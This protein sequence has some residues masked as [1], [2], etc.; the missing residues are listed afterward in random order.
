MHTSI[1]AWLLSL[2]RDD[3]SEGAAIIAAVKERDEARRAGRALGAKWD[4]LVG[5][6]A[7][8]MLSVG[9]EQTRG[10]QQLDG[11]TVSSLKRAC[12]ALIGSR[13]EAPANLRREVG[14][15][16]EKELG[17]ADYGAVAS[18]ILAWLDSLPEGGKG[19]RI[20]PS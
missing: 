1:A 2:S 16:T 9:A 13:E 15:L 5:I 8:L 19:G 14:E 11:S 10:D 12:W 4:L 7:A 3:P 17:R 6:V 20:L 18:T